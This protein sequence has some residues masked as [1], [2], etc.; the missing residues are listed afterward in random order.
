[1]QII[2]K[3]RYKH[4]Q[5]KLVDILRIIRDNGKP[6]KLYRDWLEWQYE[7]TQDS[8]KERVDRKYFML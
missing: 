3:I 6:K 4:L 8:P 1:M 7:L 5:P 2:V